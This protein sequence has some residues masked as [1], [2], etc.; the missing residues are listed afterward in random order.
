M[1]RAARRWRRQGALPRL[2][3][4][5]WGR[6]QPAQRQGR[7]LPLLPAL[8]AERGGAEVDA[9]ARAGGD[10]TLGRALRPC[11]VV[12][13]LVTHAR[14]HAGAATRRCADSSAAVTGVGD[15][16][17]AVRDV[18][19]RPAGRLQ[20]L[21]KEGH[22]EPRGSRR[23]L[24]MAALTR[25]R[26]RGATVSMAIESSPKGR[27]ISA[28]ADMYSRRR[29]P[30]R[31]TKSAPRLRRK[32]RGETS[33]RFVACGRSSRPTRGAHVRPSRPPRP[34]GDRQSGAHREAA[35]PG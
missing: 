14:T 18:G 7:R 13:R 22:V 20:R 34:K 12:I 28:G 25:C 35:R 1:T 16:E 11:P 24:R 31:E 6:H 29:L 2:L 4:H 17:R 15:G 10:A 33:R 30:D 9:R 32:V 5:V 23:P 8:P 3:P 19:G 26:T 27:R 21:R